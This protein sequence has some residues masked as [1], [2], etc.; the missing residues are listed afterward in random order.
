MK[1]DGENS[2]CFVQ[3]AHCDIQTE[4]SW[5]NQWRGTSYFSHGS[6]DSRGVMVLI[7]NKVE[8]K[9]INVILDNH[10]RYIIIHCIL[11]DQP[12]L[13]INVYAPNIESEQIKFFKHIFLELSKFLELGSFSIIIGGDFNCALS[14][15]D[16]RGGNYQQKY[17]T[18]AV[19]EDLIDSYDL[20]DIWRLRHPID[21]NFTWRTYSPLIQRRLDYFLLSNELQPYIVNT[22]ILPG[23]S[24]D[25]SVI[26]IEINTFPNEKH[27]PS[28]WRFNINR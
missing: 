16:A 22:D 4:N 19:I 15:K 24:S 25:H 2:I 20:V 14:P 8:F 26:L 17:G 23:V 7:G 12:F 5:R 27:G 6:R 3:E 10:G 11:H 21:V 18:T 9:C 28:Y 1:H 13:L